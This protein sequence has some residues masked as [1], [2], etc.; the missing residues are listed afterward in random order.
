MKLLFSLWL[1]LLSIIPITTPLPSAANAQEYFFETVE[2]EY[3]YFMQSTELSYYNEDLELVVVQGIYGDVS[4][5]GICFYS[6]EYIIVLKTVD[7]YYTL[8]QIS[9]VSAMVI[10]LKA[11]VT[12]EVVVYNKNGEEYQLP[13][14]IILKKFIDSDLDYNTLEE[15]KNNFK[16]FMQLNMYSFRLPFFKVLI[17][18]LCSVIAVSMLGLLVMFIFK[19]GFFDKNKRKQG[20]LDIKSILEAET[21]D[22]AS[23]DVFKDCEVINSNESNSNETVI[24]E[25]VKEQIEDIKGY[26]QSLGYITDYKLLSEEEK[27]KIMLELMRL[28]DTEQITL[29]KY[30]EETYQL[31]KK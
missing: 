4:S 20:V 8:P 30:Y 23:E 9:E 15:G 6:T 29:K 17:V 16:S 28:K 27:N 10:A 5:Y 19:K 7:G 26:L 31:W 18:V 25:E 24:Q 14:R 2:N 22:K 21:D 3:K 13:K 1:A 12:Y 11:D